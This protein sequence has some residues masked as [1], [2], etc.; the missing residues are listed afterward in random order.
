MSKNIG[1]S[2]AIL[3]A[4]I[5]YLTNIF[6]SSINFNIGSSTIALILGSVIAFYIPNT[7]EGGRWIIS[8]ILPISII[9]LG[10]GLNIRTFFVPEIGLFGIAVAFS[11]AITSFIICY[12]AGKYFKLDLETS[13]ALGAGGAICGNSAVVAVSPSLR[14]KEERVAVIL[15]II[16]LLGLVT[17][18]LIPPLTSVLGLTEQQGGIWSGSVIHAVPQA[19][20]A[21]E[22]IGQEAMIIATAVKLSRVSL[23]FVVV[24]L[25]A[26]LGNRINKKNNQ[27]KQIGVIPYFVPGF[28]IAAIL[29][30]WILPPNLSEFLAIIG[31][32][33]LLPLLASVG[34]FIT[35][36]SL[37]DAGGSILIVGIL[38]TISMLISSYTMIIML[39]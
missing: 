2:I 14:L 16:N 3:I 34:F 9:L 21:G 20:A 10:F 33:L 38:A 6:L 29:S 11:T 24:P 13:V 39:S 15:A 18:L 4:L 19:I 5:A 37:K 7:G 25:C 36:E 30:T 8:Y 31:K 12:I 17:F 27:N 23:L 22:T 32:Y 1:I 28:I 26:W 35:R